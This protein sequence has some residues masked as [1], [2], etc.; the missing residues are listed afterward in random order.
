MILELKDVSTCENKE[1]HKEAE[2][3]LSSFDSKLGSFPFIE[4]KPFKLHIVNQENKRLLIT[5]ETDV[6]IAIP[7]DRCLEEVPT[8]I[9][10]TFDKEIPLGESEISKDEEVEEADYMTGFHLDVDRLVYDEILVNLPMKVLCK[11]DCKGICRKC[12]ANL[13]LQACDCENTELDPRMAAIQDVF[14]KFKEV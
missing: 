7:C 14:N 12:G 2:I 6:I 1:V 13:N 3:E 9:H 5:G 8:E 11:D 4:K 10:F